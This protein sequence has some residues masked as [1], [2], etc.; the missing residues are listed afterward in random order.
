MSVLLDALKKA[1]EQKLLK[2]N[3]QADELVETAVSPPVMPS[4]EKL[5]FSLVSDL[6]AEQPNSALEEPKAPLTETPSIE[7]TLSEVPEKE[8]LGFNEEPISSTEDSNHPLH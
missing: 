6:N 4:T 2:Q 1:A 5:S 3:L 8:V 7:L